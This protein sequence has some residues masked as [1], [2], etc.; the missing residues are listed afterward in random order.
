MQQNLQSNLKSFL[1]IQKKENKLLYLFRAFV[2]AF[3]KADILAALN[4]L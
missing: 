3:K 2:V 1:R 4:Q